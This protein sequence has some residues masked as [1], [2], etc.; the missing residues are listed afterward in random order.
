MWANTFCG[1]DGRGAAAS[2]GTD[3]FLAVAKTSVWADPMGGRVAKFDVDWSSRFAAAAVLLLTAM[4]PVSGTRAQVGPSPSPQVQ[5]RMVKAVDKTLQEG[6][7]AKLPPHI[8]TLLGLSKE[9]EFPVMQDAVRTGKVV[10]G[11]DVSAAN[12]H[13]VVLF[14][15]NETTNDQT[16]YLTSKQGALQKVVKVKEGVGEVQKITVE[17]RKAFEKE[18]QFWLDRLAPVEK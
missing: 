5:K 3:V 6:L 17:D 11:F 9:E 2:Y 13:D 4:M 18:R 1:Y 16:L 14:V 15:V 8:S 10:Q 7:Q 12:K